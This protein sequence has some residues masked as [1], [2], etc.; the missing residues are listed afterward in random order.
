MFAACD[1][2]EQRITLLHRLGMDGSYRSF[3][4]GVPGDIYEILPAALGIAL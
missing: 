3:S 1:P 4:D 2:N